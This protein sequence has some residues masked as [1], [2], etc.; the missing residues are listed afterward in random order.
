M[1]ITILSLGTERVR[2]SA[3]DALGGVVVV[4]SSRLARARRCCDIGNLRFG[5]N[6]TGGLSKP[7]SALRTAGRSVSRARRPVGPLCA[8]V[9]HRRACL[10]ISR[11]R[12]VSTAS[13]R[14]ASAPPA[15]DLADSR[16]DGVPEQ[17]AKSRRRARDAGGEAARGRRGHHPHRLT[18][19]TPSRGVRQH[20]LRRSRDQGTSPRPVSPV[21]ELRARSKARVT[22]AMHHQTYDPIRFP[23]P[24]TA[25][26]RETPND[27][28]TAR[29]CIGTWIRRR[30]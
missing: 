24:L 14:F 27:R 26:H 4:S 15:T 6:E 25:K 22:R 1:C 8:A 3:D 11:S 2:E 30:S 7:K 13:P 29:A 16:H 9:P 19:Q 17:K 12:R 18:L 23:P 21:R 10:A 28:H 5:G 20:R